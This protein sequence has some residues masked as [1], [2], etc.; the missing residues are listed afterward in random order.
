MLK[1]LSGVLG[2]G[3]A[4]AVAGP[5][6]RAAVAP[7]DMRT[8]TGLGEFVTVSKLKALP[9]DGTPVNVPV[10]VSAPKDGWTKHPPTT[11]GG[12]FLR[13][14]GKAVRAWSTICP[15][16][17][18]GIDFDGSKGKFACPCH[19]SWFEDD[20]AVASGPSPRGM[21]ELQARIVGDEVQVK[22]EKFKIGTSDKVPA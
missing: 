11:V 3:V 8:V 13:R 1:V 12:V 2:G 20:G 19:E 10:V 18:C 15:H 22:F 6:L 5:A 4:C 9:A 7:F 16:L 17:G 21:D 14:Q